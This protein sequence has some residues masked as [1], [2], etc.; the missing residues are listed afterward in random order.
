[1]EVFG[2]RWLASMVV[3]SYVEEGVHTHMV[4]LVCNYKGVHHIHCLGTDLGMAPA[5]SELMEVVA[6]RVVYKLEAPPT[7]DYPILDTCSHC[8]FHSL[9]HNLKQTHSQMGE[10]S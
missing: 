10:N 6:K 5:H 2:C 4:G 1:M 8:S 3:Q 7:F 9:Q